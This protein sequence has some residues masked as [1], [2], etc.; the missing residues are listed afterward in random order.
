MTD[1]VWWAASHL[2]VSQRTAIQEVFSSHVVAVFIEGGKELG[3]G[4]LVAWENRKFLL[5]ASHVIAGTSLSRISFF[6]RPAGTI[7]ERTAEEAFRQGGRPSI[8][9]YPLDVN[10]LLESDEDH[11]D[12]AVLEVFSSRNI[13]AG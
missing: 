12:L 3:T 13:G 5:T 1:P 10:L 2:N 7:V 4:T 11:D 9:G 6:T 8:C